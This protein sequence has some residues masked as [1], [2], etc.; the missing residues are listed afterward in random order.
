MSNENTAEAVSL[1]DIDFSEVHDD[2]VESPE[3]LDDAPINDIEPKDAP[4][5]SETTDEQADKVEYIEPPEYFP[6]EFRDHFQA[7]QKLEGGKDY[8]QH[9][10]SQYSEH[11]NYINSKLDEVAKSKHDIETFNQ[12]QQA[13]Q[14]LNQI[15][16]QQAVHPAMGVAQLAHYGQ[17]LYNDPKG[18]INEI[19]QR[20]NLD[21]NQLVEEQPYIDPHV[22]DQ[23][24]TL[25][26][27]NQQFQQAIGQ[28]QQGH[29]EQ[30]NQ[31]I[32]NQ[33][34]EFEDL[35]DSSGQPAH[36]YFQQVHQTMA[37]LLKIPNNNINDLKSAYDRAVMLDVDI[38]N[39]V[40]QKQE[41]EKA[42][43]LHKEAEKASQS[44]TRVGSKSK[45]APDV[46]RS[47]DNIFDHILDD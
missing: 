29:T 24:R 39:E 45:D 26:Q 23:L 15:W 38:Q 35:K 10:A 33:I 14:P 22:Q 46:K 31:A 25:Q 11:Q 30:Q 44:D 17:M 8:A 3:V 5:A 13:L 21:L 16:Q 28:F 34:A 9:W 18:L 41:K 40:R 42:E 1:D 12:Y 36:P 32:N 27:Q 43:Q 47:L 2:T 37:E 7:L 6:K 19:A 4:E 20:A